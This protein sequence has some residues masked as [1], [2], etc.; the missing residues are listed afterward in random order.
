MTSEWGKKKNFLELLNVCVSNGFLLRAV[1]VIPTWLD[2]SFDFG[3]DQRIERRNDLIQFR[4]AR[5]A[6]Q[7]RALIAS[8]DVCDAMTRRS[9]KIISKIEIFPVSSSSKAGASQKRSQLMMKNKSDERLSRG[10]F[11]SHSHFA[12]KHRMQIHISFYGE[13]MLSVDCR[14]SDI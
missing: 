12:P 14:S 1:E 10:V 2:P 11:L 6:R 7:P 5:E 13:L 3:Q 4:K 9:Q 8:S